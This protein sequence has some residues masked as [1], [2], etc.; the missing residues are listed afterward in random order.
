[1]P[2]GFRPPVFAVWPGTFP[3]LVTSHQTQQAGK[4]AGS[5]IC[6]TVSEGDRGHLSHP[7]RVTCRTHWGNP[8]AGI[9]LLQP[10]CTRCPGETPVPWPPPSHPKQS[11]GHSQPLQTIKCAQRKT[12]AQLAPLCHSPFLKPLASTFKLLL[13]SIPKARAVPSVSA[14][15]LEFTSKRRFHHL[16]NVSPWV[17]FHCTATTKC[18]QWNNLLRCKLLKT[19]TSLLVLQ[20]T[21]KAS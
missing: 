8:I 13:W 6:P 14:V 2:L 5:W 7:A 18:W 12:E 21:W 4:P 15:G 20:E 16:I 1:M 19:I 17:D 3:L 11:T 10:L 9:T